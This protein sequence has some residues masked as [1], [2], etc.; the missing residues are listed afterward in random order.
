[1]VLLPLLFVFILSEPCWRW[2]KSAHWH[3]DKADVALLDSLALAWRVDT[4]QKSAAQRSLSADSRGRLPQKFFMFDPNVAT[5]DELEQLGFTPKLAQRVQNYRSKGGRFRKKE[6]LLRMYGM[7]TLFYTQLVPYIVVGTP[8]SSG[9]YQGR[10][11]KLGQN[12]RRDTF[13]SKPHPVEAPFDV[14]KA[15]TS[16]LEA[17]RGIG[18]KLSRRIIKYRSSLGGFVHVDQFKE[19][20]GLDS[21]VLRQLLNTA[22]VAPDF[23]PDRIDLNVADE[24]VLDSHPYISRQEARAIVAYRFQHGRFDSVSE[25]RK[26]PMFNEEKVRRLEPYLK[27]GE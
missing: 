1:M 15:D 20:F 9:R 25:L 6:D 21:A 11:N 23:L 27:T 12:A 22:F 5:A 4:L 13:F 19:V 18:P 17:I 3:P 26:L 16:R 2:W 8:P 10:A 14:N 24:K 7:D